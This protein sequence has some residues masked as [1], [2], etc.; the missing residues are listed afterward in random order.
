M[1]AALREAGRVKPARAEIA[2]ADEPLMAGPIYTERAMARGGKVHLCKPHG[3]DRF[4]AAG[5][6]ELCDAARTGVWPFA[7]GTLVITAAP[8]MTLIDVDGG[9]DPASLAR[10][11]ALAA[12]EAI[13]ALGIGGSIGIDFPT[14]ASRAVRQEI[15]AIIDTRLSRP[16]ECTAINGFGL[17]QI[18]R[19]RTGP[20][21]IEYEQFAREESDAL[22]LIRMAERAQGAG[23]LTLT[24]RSGVA[25]QFDSN[26][27]WL[28]TL[29]ARTGR[30]VEVRIDN[31]LEGCGHA[32]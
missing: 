22:R 26:P 25:A 7:G 1:R 8:A 31:D 19:R 14:V 24:V 2:P 23:R 17:M 21:L 20:S 10:A 12:A 11:G 3:V 29:Q 30:A 27:G 5:W 18:V 15:A 16:F 28:A 4:E 9:G 6:S 32:Q 13:D